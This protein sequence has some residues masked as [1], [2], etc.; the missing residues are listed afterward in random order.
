MKNRFAPNEFQPEP[1][2]QGWLQPPGRKPPTAVAAGTLPPGGDGPGGDDYAALKRHRALRLRA[3]GLV[4]V[5]SSASFLLLS[6]AVTALLA[7]GAGAALLAEGL[8]QARGFIA[9]RTKR[10]LVLYRSR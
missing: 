10:R 4:F 5:A 8:H 2:E 6:P 7:L 1:E 3:L 9:R